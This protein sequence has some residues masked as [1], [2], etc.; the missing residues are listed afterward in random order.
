MYN[1][2]SEETYNDGQVI[3]KEGSSGDW[4]YMIIFGSVEISKNVGGKNFVLSILQKGEIFGELNLIAGIKR[5]ATA[6]A[7]GETTLGLIDRT[8][9]DDEFNKLSADFRSVLVAMVHRFE[10]TVSRAIEF[11]CRSEVRA[12]KSLSL[13][14]KDRQAFVRAY[15]TNISSG[16]LFIKTERPLPRGE[17]FFLKLQLPDIEEPLKISCEVVWS[18]KPTDY[19]KGPPGMGVKFRQMSG[20]D[21]QILDEYLKEVT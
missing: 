16:G 9:L 6:R 18:R 13:T 17:E 20:K 2:A 4:V 11:S 10:K 19:E 7:I 3:F 21:R 14:F 12:T 8:P 15:A 1:I 5:T